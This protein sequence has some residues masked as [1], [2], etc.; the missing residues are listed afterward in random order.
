MIHAPEF[1]RNFDAGF[2]EAS[3]PAS[4]A[5]A[6][7]APSRYTART[8][9]GPVRFW[10]RVNSKASAIPNQPGEFWPVV[11][12]ADDALLSWYQFASAGSVEAIQA[13]Q[14]R[15]YDKVAAQHS[16]EHEVWQLTRDAGLPILLHHVRTPPEP[17]F[18]HHALHY[19]DAEDARE[20]GRL[21]GGQI[22]DWLEACAASPETLEQH[23]W[24]VHWAE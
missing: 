5:R 24:R 13:Q 22:R 19:L 14:Q 12:D 8:P 16:F 6:K 1:Y 9:A 4:V 11:S 10:F 17:R 23:M 18:P 7:G 21:L 2:A 3:P 20:W 15:V